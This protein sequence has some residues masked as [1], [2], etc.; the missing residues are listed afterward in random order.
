MTSIN[1]IVYIPKERRKTVR[2]LATE[3]AINEHAIP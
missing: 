2:P 3:T 1:K